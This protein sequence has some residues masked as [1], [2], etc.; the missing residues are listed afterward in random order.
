[1]QLKLPHTTELF[2]I[3]QFEYY[4]LC[5]GILSI[6]YNSAIIFPRVCS[7]TSLALTPVLDISDGFLVTLNQSRRVTIYI[8]K[9][10]RFLLTHF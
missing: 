9:G 6:C 3:N 7:G 10:A 2:Y 4:V 5:R 1:M 8:L